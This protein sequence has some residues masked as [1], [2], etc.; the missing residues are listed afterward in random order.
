MGFNYILFFMNEEKILDIGLEVGKLLLES[1]AEIY[2]VEETM[3]RVCS[4]YSKVGNVDS[5][6]M[7]TGIILSMEIDGKTISK[8]CRVKKR[9]VNLECIERI[10]SLSREL[11]YTDYTLEEVEQKLKEIKEKPTFKEWMMI[12]FG[13]IGAGAFAMF[14]NGNGTEIACSILI[15]MLVRCIVLL[16]RQM[17]INDFLYNVLAS[18]M[19]GFSSYWFSTLFNVRMETLIISGIMLLIPGLAIT[20]AIRDSMAG[21]YLSALVRAMEAL[22]TGCAIALG[23]GLALRMVM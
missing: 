21:D 11:Q 7:A 15:G 4:S 22:F 20:N 2:R 1:G 8:V 23:V 14:F 19:I 16:L 18:S 6:V 9:S 13:G 12:L 5:Y 3:N 10:N 17:K